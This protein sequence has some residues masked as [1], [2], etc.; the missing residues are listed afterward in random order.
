MRSGWHTLLI[1]S[2]TE[3]RRLLLNSAAVGGV[4]LFLLSWGVSAAEFGVI[5]RRLKTN[6]GE[7]HE[8]LP[9]RSD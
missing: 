1:I 4:G 5:P 2:T 7:A 9:T 8:P 6:L 3:H